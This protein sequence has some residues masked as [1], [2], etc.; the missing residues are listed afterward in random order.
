MTCTYTWL[1]GDMKFIFSCCKI[2][3]SFTAPMSQV[4]VFIH[5]SCENWSINELPFLLFVLDKPENVQLTINDSNICKGDIISVTCS[6]DGKP[7][8]HTYQLFENDIPVPDSD[9]AGVWRRTMSAQGSFT[10]RCVANNA[11]GTSDKNVT[12]TVE[13]NWCFF[14]FLYS[15]NLF[16]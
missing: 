4:Q 2:F 15:N 14:F 1:L 6:A 10:Y 8:V 9:T 3:H 16:G 11:V 5:T 13:G 12:L 7:D